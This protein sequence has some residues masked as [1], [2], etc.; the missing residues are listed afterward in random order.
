MV[1]D[2]VS[3][4]IIQLCEERKWTPNALANEA[5]LPASTLYSVLNAKPNTTIYTI[6]V[7]CDGLGISLVEFFDCPL[8]EDGEQEL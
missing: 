4:R 3:K 2:N 8:F 7:I 6:K 1:A 5:G